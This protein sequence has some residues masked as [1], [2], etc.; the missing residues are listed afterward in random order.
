LKISDAETWKGGNCWSGSEEES[1]PKPKEPHGEQELL[2]DYLNSG[3]EPDPNF[4][5]S[6]GR[7]VEIDENE[8]RK[9]EGYS[10]ESEKERIKRI[11]REVDE[12]RSE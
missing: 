2:N 11:L 12:K 9:N 1:K 4:P 3:V 10:H 8:L 5:R 7:D 6:K